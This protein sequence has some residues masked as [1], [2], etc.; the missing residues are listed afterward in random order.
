MAQ[1]LASYAKPADFWAI[2]WQLAT[3]QPRAGE[4]C[5]WPTLFINRLIQF[6]E[7]KEKFPILVRMIEEVL[8]V[9]ELF[10]KLPPVPEEKPPISC[11]NGQDMV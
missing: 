8:D 3:F 10:E 4:S 7:D 5:H 2:T 9:R 11:S 6:L 1:N